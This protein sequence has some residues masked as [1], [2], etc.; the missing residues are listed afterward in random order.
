MH[1]SPIV[2][3]LHRWLRR[4]CPAVHAA[5]ATVVVTV[6]E[7]LVLGAKLALTH[8]GRN[9]RSAAFAKHS[10]KRVDRLLGNG[11]LHRERSDIYGAIA[12]WLLAAT[13][14]PLLLIDW[15]DCGSR[16]PGR[17]KR[18]W[19]LLRAAVPLGGRAIP[20]YEEVHPLRAYNS[21][22]TH[23][24]FLQHLRAVVPASCRPILI[25][26]AGFR[27]PWFREVERYGWDWIGRVRNQVKYRV[28]RE[29]EGGAWAYTR[30]LYRAATPTPRHL[31]RAVL[32]RRQSYACELYLVRQYRRGPGRPRS[33]H[34]QHATARRC[35]K[36]HKDPWLLA[37]S[38]PHTSGAARR[39]VKL[40][41]LRMKIEEGIRDTKDARWG[42][43][44]R[45]ARSRRA[46]RMEV[47]LLLATLG[48]LAAWLSGLAAE[49]H[50]WARH[51]QANTVRTRR[52]L[53]TVFV[54]RQ[55]LIS[56]RFRL[57]RRD[58][59]HALTRLP[60]LV[61]RYATVP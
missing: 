37:T 29:A 23:R 5:R 42:F 54:G 19:L 9:L 41:A 32:S 43:A 14:R 24:R 35:R 44:L 3:V 58:L 8:L 45:Y 1:A 7:A 48:T 28:A 2:P 11:H 31:G 40:Y 4:A 36:L 51:F 60:V 49:A 55:L 21:P 56:L 26:D 59:R 39:V 25:T 61:A 53:S 33:A 30:A 52:V 46:E 12:R 10:I 22:R 16:A 47:L 15:A 57:P 13:P 6:V 50:A 38:L 20:I 18:R 34:G 17:A 27:G